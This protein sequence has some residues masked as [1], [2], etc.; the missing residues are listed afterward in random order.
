M[1]CLP[2]PPSGGRSSIN[3]EGTPPFSSTPSTTFGY[4]SASPGGDAQRDDAQQ[5]RTG[6]RLRV[7]DRRKRTGGHDLERVGAFSV[8]VPGGSYQVAASA[9]GY[10]EA[11]ETVQVSGSTSTTLALTRTSRTFTP[12]PATRRSCAGLAPT[13]WSFKR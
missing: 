6:F 13:I 2:S 7:S 4:S 12:L 5:W 10:L 8:S 3:R 1:A 11:T 9:P